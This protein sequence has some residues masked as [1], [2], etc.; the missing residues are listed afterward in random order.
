[1]Q[2]AVVDESRRADLRNGK[3]IDLA[4]QAGDGE[5]ALLDGEGNLLALAQSRADGWQAQPT[6]VFDRG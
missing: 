5:I 1:M 3:V 2:R 4:D 6:K